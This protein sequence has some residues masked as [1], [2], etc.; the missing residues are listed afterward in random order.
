MVR[1]ESLGD[2]ITLIHSKIRLYKSV[3]IRTTESNNKNNIPLTSLSF[4]PLSQFSNPRIQKPRC[5]ITQWW[6]RSEKK[7]KVN[8]NHREV[9]IPIFVIESRF[10]SKWM[11]LRKELDLGMKFRNVYWLSLEAPSRMGEGISKWRS[12]YIGSRKQKHTRRNSSA[13]R[14]R[15]YLWITGEAPRRS[16]FTLIRSI[17]S[18]GKLDY[19]KIAI[20]TITNTPQ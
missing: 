13:D 16:V 15:K 5:K 17:H 8:Q 12:K 9:S 14:R 1:G 7:N 2:L 11:K 10:E 18:V 4:I 19:S 3:F 20:S 6:H